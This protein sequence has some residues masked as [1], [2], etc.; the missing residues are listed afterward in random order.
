[1]TVALIWAADRAGA[2]GSGN[3]IPWHVPEDQKR[4]RELTTGH[5]V[6]MGRRTWD[7]LPPRFRPLPN[8]HN[9]VVTRDHRWS[10][11]GATAVTDLEAALRVGHDDDDTVVVSGGEQIYALAL[12]HADA[13]WITDIDLTIDDPDA[14]APSVPSDDWETVTDHGWQTSTTGIRYRYRDLARR[15]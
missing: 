7:S 9:I 1:M 8:R 11:D 15:R 12:P 6:I 13:L 14:F 2:I 5:P 4:F 10:A 3:T